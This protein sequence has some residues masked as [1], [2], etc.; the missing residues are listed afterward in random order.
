MYVVVAWLN[1]MF[2]IILLEIAYVRQI[3]FAREM[4][5]EPLN[6]YWQN[7][8]PRNIRGGALQKWADTHNDS[9]QHLL[10][11]ATTFIIIK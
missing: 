3:K 9:K 2:C 7:C 5:Q 8:T 10:T 11:M 1:F 6:I 4:L